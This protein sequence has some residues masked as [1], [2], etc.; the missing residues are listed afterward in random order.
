MIESKI[1]VLRKAAQVSTTQSSDNIWC[2]VAGNEEMVNNVAYSAISSKDRVKIL[3]REH[4]D[5]KESFVRKKFD[6]IMVYGDTDKIR[7]LSLI[8][9]ENG[10]AYL[11]IA[12]YY[13]KNEPNLLLLSWAR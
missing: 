13:V 4:V 8:C 9:K 7:E 10:G 3:F 5:L 6:F 11:K 1:K 2:V 12:P